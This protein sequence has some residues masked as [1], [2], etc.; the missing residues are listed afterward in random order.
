[1]TR[2]TTSTPLARWT[3]CSCDHARPVLLPQAVQP[4]LDRPL[5]RD[6]ARGPL[7][8]RQAQSAALF[9]P[10]ANRSEWEWRA[11]EDYTYMDGLRFIT[12]SMLADVSDREGPHPQDV[13][14]AA[15]A[16]FLIAAAAL[17]SV[18]TSL[19][20]ESGQFGVADPPRSGSP[21]VPTAASCRAP[22]SIAGARHGDTRR[23]RRGI[24]AARRKWRALL[25]ASLLMAHEALSLAFSTPAPGSG[26]DAGATADLGN[27][28]TW[29]ASHITTSSEPSGTRSFGN[30]ACDGTASVTIGWTQYD[31]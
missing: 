21:V 20:A 23:S 6:Q 30:L 5:G 8:A 17:T 28:R 4:W 3:N 7:V 27:P 25:L 31:N 14:V 29:T 13:A 11:H 12:S 2:W 10:P 16:L 15:A 9:V 19:L 1:M 26:D 18:A 22:R 24:H